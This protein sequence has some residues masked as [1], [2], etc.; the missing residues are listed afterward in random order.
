MESAY[1]LNHTGATEMLKNLIVIPGN[2]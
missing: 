2:G 1:I